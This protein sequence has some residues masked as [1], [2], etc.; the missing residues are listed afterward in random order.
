MLHGRKLTGVLLTERLTN[1]R[2]IT[3]LAGG[4]RSIVE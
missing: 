2:T 1:L 3:D 4:R